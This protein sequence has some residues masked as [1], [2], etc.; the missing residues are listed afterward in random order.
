MRE[1]VISKHVL[2]ENMLT[3]NLLC[4]KQ[5]RSN[6]EQAQQDPK[7]IVTLGIQTRMTRM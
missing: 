6:Y 7:Y 1:I 2:I 3:K 4:T 5:C